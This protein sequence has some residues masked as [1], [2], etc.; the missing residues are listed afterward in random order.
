[1][2]ISCKRFHLD[3]GDISICWL[4]ALYCVTDWQGVDIVEFWAKNLLLLFVYNCS[5]MS[6]TIW[7]RYVWFWC[8]S[9]YNRISWYTVSNAALRSIHII[10]TTLFWS[11]AAWMLLCICNMAVS[12]EWFSFYDDCMISW[13]SLTVICVVIWL[14]HCELFF[15]WALRCIPG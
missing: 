15:Q 13:R 3:P 1:M 4:N 6:E 9:R 12:V 5:N 10:R 14:S 7:G 11:N 8:I 2:D